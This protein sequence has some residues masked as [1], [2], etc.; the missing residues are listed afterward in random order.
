MYAPNQNFKYSHFGLMSRPCPCQYLTGN[1]MLFVISSSLVAVSSP[2]C[3][4]EFYLNRASSF[5][6]ISP[7]HLSISVN[8]LCY[9]P[10]ALRGH[11]T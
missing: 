1:F 10:F 6:H 5:C 2:S 7:I 11:V 8:G 3:L 4:L 9:R